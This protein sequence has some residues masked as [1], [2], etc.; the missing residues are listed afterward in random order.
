M[1]RFCEECAKPAT[2]FEVVPLCGDCYEGK[3]LFYERIGMKLDSGIPLA[4]AMRQAE[5]ELLAPEKRQEPL[6][7]VT[8]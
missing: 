2:S 8:K 3:H 1:N 6:F 7:E 4:L 5:E